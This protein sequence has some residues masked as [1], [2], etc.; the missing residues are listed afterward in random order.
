M[1]ERLSVK[2]FAIIK[3]LDIIFNSGLNIIT[4]ETGA[5]KSIIIEAVHMALGGR[6]DSALVRTGCSKALI[7]LV[8]SDPSSEEDIILTREIQSGGRSTCRINDE[9]VT[10]SK[11]ASLCRKYVDIHGQYDNQA[12]LNP[13]NHINILDSYDFNGIGSAKSDYIELFSEYTVLADNLS[14]LRKQQAEGMRKKDFMEFELAEIEKANPS[15]GEDD[16]LKE[17]LSFLQNRE[18]IFS[19]AGS[20]YEQLYAREGSCSELLMSSLSE[21]KKISSLSSQFSD[22][23]EIIEDCY[24]R[25][26]EV[27]SVLSGFTDSIDFSP[28]EI[29]SIISRQETIEALKKKYGGSVEAVLE[30]KEK[31]AE[32]LSLID[33]SDEFKKELSEKINRQKELVSESAALLS[34]LRKEAALDMQDAVN[35]ELSE[36]GFKNSRFEVEFT[37]AAFG[38]D[39]ADK[40]EFLISTNK[41]EALKPLAKIASGGEISRIMLAFKRITGSCSSVPTFIFDE[42][43]TGISGHAAA[44]VGKK[45]YQISADHQI[46]C[47]THLPQIAVMGDYHYLIEKFSDDSET[48]TTVS[49]MDRETLLREIARLSGSG[50]LTEGARMNAEEM[51]TGAALRKQGIKNQHNV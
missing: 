29:D 9:I 28:D 19:S 40:I 18:K 12:L 34:R 48:Y 11:L 45:L 30:Y 2:N 46:I 36:L 27:S 23:Q 47:I 3:D 7:Q 39:G 33:S 10:L 51:L 38:P 35:R 26:E 32:E 5:G 13:E 14:R 42:I 41:G 8:I 17:R 24:Y 1:I 43:D 20:A 6:A 4:G 25:L 31:L 21:I 22:I 37:P 50:E 44:V 16:E 49:E 15:P